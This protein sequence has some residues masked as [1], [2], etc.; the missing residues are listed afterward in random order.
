LFAGGRDFNRA[1]SDEKFYLF[2]CAQCGLMFIA[3]PPADLGRYYPID[4]H[5]MPASADG[6]D[7]HL[8]AQRFKIDLLKRFVAGGSLL[9]IGPSNGIFC[10][11]AQKAG[12]EVSAI[13]MDEDC[14]R[15]LRDDLGVRTTASPDPAAVLA[16]DDRTYD[17]ICLWH[18]IEHLQRPW[19]VLA[20]AARRMKPGGVLLV[21]APNPDAWQ[22]RLLG[23]RWPHHDLP[24]H[25]FALPIPWLIE[26][27]KRHGLTTEMVTTRDEGSLFWNRF[28]WAML[29]RSI[30]GSRI[31]RG[32]SWR[33]G[34]LF[35]YL[36]QP[37]EGREGRG[38]CYTAVLR[39]S[40]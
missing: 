19:D 15:F 17:A 6:L 7:P 39:G 32:L 33:V 20:Q 5:S 2:R 3:N 35:G 1:I 14:A 10:R 27:G 9:E 12:F 28:T 25:L 36:L 37:W 31:L 40:K 26:F 23:A 11:L 30:F 16:T 13:E 18:T 21:A 8:P 29:L 24:R 22:A 38:A 4:Y 34:M